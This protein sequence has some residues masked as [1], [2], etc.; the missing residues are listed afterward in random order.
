MEQ[1]VNREKRPSILLKIL[2]FL[3]HSLFP[4]FKMLRI[5]KLLTVAEQTYVQRSTKGQSTYPKEASW[6]AKQRVR[7]LLVALIIPSVFILS[8]VGAKVVISTNPVL[9]KGFEKVQEN[10]VKFNFKEA[11]NKWQIANRDPSVGV[12]IRLAFRMILIGL[13]LSLFMGYYATNKNPL[14]KGSEEFKSVL[15]S[16]GYQKKE[17][18]NLILATPLGFLYQISSGGSPK[19]LAGTDRIWQSLNIRINDFVE[20]PDTRSIVF[21]KKAYQLKAGDQYGYDK[22]E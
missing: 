10:V 14:V 11:K 4:I 12:D 9:V 1:E 13:G 16:L 15:V 7:N 2:M 22:Y 21:F 6:F 19:E 5:N 17:D 18:D 20:H 8:L 3:F